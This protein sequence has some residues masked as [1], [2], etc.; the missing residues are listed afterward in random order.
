[1]IKRSFQGLSIAFETVKIIDKLIEIWPNEV[2]DRRYIS[3]IAWKKTLYDNRSFRCTMICHP[4]DT[5]VGGR[6]MSWSP[7]ITGGLE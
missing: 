2:C 3:L 1:L 4:L 7:E 5:Q 6:P